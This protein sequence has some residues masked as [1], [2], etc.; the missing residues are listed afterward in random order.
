MNPATILLYPFDCRGV[1]GRAAYRRNLSVLVLVGALITRLDLLP[2]DAAW[3][4]TI[5]ATAIGLSFDARRYHDM[6]RS[7]AWIVWANLIGA[8]LAVVA[9]QFIPNALDY[10]PLPS[11]WR[12]DDAGQAVFGRFVLPAIVGVVIGNSQSRMLI[13]ESEEVERGG[14]GRTLIQQYESLSLGIVVHASEVF[15]SESQLL[16]KSL[17]E[18]LESMKLLRRG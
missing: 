9:F 4:W 6:G 3:G 18:Y 16:N 8:A 14:G 12:V 15:K 2:G 7:A 17:G 5:L 1:L 11:D 13:L 10:I